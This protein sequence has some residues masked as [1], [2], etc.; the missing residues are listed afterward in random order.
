MIR[1]VTPVLHVRRTTT[2]DTMLAGRPI[3]AN[4]KVVLWYVSG[5]RD[6]KVIEEPNRLIIPDYS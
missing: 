1:Y 3:P 4:S 6:D 2:R 5:N